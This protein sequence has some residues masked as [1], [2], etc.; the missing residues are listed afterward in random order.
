M[1]PSRRLQ[2]GLRAGGTLAAAWLAG[3]ACGSS[4]P[5]DQAFHAVIPLP[6][7]EIRFLPVL[8][9]VH[10]DPAEA[11]ARLDVEINGRDVSERFAPSGP[12]HGVPLRPV[13]P[14]QEAYAEFDRDDGIRG[15]DN[16]W[17][18]QLRGADGRVLSRRSQRFR[19]RPAPL[20]IAYR[21]VEHVGGGAP[22]E[23]PARL[24]VIGV[25][26][27]PSPDFG[28]GQSDLFEPRDIV[29]SF[30]N[31]AG[32]GT[33]YLPLGHYRLL[34]SRGLRY[35]VAEARVGPE[36]GPVT[37][38]LSRVVDT[39]G[40]VA[41][42]LHVHSIASGDSSIPLRMRVASFLATDV[43]VIVASDHNW[44][45]DYDTTLAS[46]PGASDRLRVIAGTE[47]SFPRLGHWNVWPLAQNGL[48]RVLEARD[49][50]R[51]N[52][53]PARL[54]DT[55]SR[56]RAQA[57]AQTL[58]SL[59]HPLGVSNLPTRAARQRY[60]EDPV[61]NENVGYLA[62][63]DYDEAAPVPTAFDPSRRVP[64]DTLRL[65]ASPHGDDAPLH[66]NLGFDLLEVYNRNDHG[67]YLRM[68]DIWFSWLDQGIRRTA[69]GNSD[70]HTLVL[71][72]PG[73]PRNMV[74]TAE[75]P[76]STRIADLNGALAA[77]R[78]YA[79]TGP[80]LRVR[81]RTRGGA[82][83]GLGD[84]LFSDDG[85][86]EL[87]V[88]V[89]AAPWIPVSELRVFANGEP[90]ETVALDADGA[91]TRPVTRFDRAIPLRLPQ[92]GWVVVEA[93]ARPGDPAPDGDYAVVAPDA[94]PIAFSNPI[95]IEISPRRDQ[96][97]ASA[98]SGGS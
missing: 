77:G 79:T 49:G 97:E 8:V 82:E 38:E 45:T 44:R 81:A 12:R 34:A 66:D 74:G 31:S 25:E 51:E 96:R 67:L 27:T 98:G 60:G 47:A 3:F 20:S 70:T 78:S 80:M 63:I 61:L 90:I 36:A 33:L 57:E 43:D 56:L 5:G 53:R 76:A 42:D 9:G 52:E 95:F 21:I 15:G 89:E 54:F 18:A 24:H 91:A 40:Q 11:G 19:V 87:H 73:L 72:R 14:A 2:T 83:A 28:P 64:N 26:G 7:Q 39:P 86:F 17:I 41:A 88:K 46:M 68:R 93:G 92:G 16:E 32:H 29:R 84:R 62:N 30:V 13:M 69:V 10:F 6:D 37:L 50:E 22:V 1:D 23:L 4:D 48:D 85:R 58:V 65:R 35:D 59:N 55:V 71:V 94:T 75:A